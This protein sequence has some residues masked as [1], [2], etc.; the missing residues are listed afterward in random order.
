MFFTVRGDG[1]LVQVT[2]R[3]HGVSVLGE[4][5]KLS[6]NAPAQHTYSGPAWAEGLDQI[7]SRGAF[8]PQQFCDFYQWR[9]YEKFAVFRWLKSWMFTQP[10]CLLR[11]IWL[12]WLIQSAFTNTRLFSRWKCL[13]R[14]PKRWIRLKWVYLNCSAPHILLAHCMLH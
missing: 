3:G 14:S 6:G 9:V 5:Q 4:I 10:Q 13:L 8:Q 11:R 7:T 2:K 12:F 1:A